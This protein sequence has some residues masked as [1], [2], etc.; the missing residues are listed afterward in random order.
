MV[1][2]LTIDFLNIVGNAFQ[3][4]KIILRDILIFTHYQ[5]NGVIEIDRDVL[6]NIRIANSYKAFPKRNTLIEQ[7]KMY[8]QL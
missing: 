5:Q 1:S 3:I 2:F 8:K 6:Y 7:M 4:S